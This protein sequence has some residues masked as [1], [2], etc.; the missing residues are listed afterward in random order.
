MNLECTDNYPC[1]VAFRLGTP[2]ASGYFTLTP[3]RRLPAI[4]GKNV[5]I[6]GSTQTR[7]TGD[8]NPDG[9]EIFIDGSENEWEDAIVFDTPCGGELGF[10][11]IGNFR[12]AAVTMRGS[13]GD[14][15]A[16]CAGSFPG[17]AYVHNSYLGVDATG[18]KAAPNGRGVV[19]GQQ[20]RGGTVSNNLISGNHRS[21][22]WIGMA[23]SPS[24]S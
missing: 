9:P 4:T 19:I 6:D 12:N 2:P 3:Q 10:V 18:T 15:A 7:L 8:T 17:G 5:L 14:V 22:V 1:T 20:M 23:S 24:V 13:Y 16:P 11:A 21:G